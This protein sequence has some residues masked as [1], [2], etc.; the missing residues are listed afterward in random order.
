MLVL[1]H[2]AE[3][4]VWF[5]ALVLT[6]AL[7]LGLVQIYKVRG[8]EA[9]ERAWQ[10]QTARLDQAR[11]VLDSDL[12]ELVRTGESLAASLTDA[13]PAGRAAGHADSTVVD[14]ELLRSVAAHGA[15][16]GVYLMPGARYA[17]CYRPDASGAPQLVWDK[18]ERYLSP[19]EPGWL[20]PL[21]EGAGWRTFVDGHDGRWVAQYGVPFFLPD[22]EGVERAAGVVFVRLEYDELRQ[23]LRAIDLGDTGY[24]FLMTESGELI[25]HPLLHEGQVGVT[26]FDMATRLKDPLL[27]DAAERAILGDAPWIDRADPASGNMSRIFFRPLPSSRWTLVG[28][29]LHREVLGSDLTLRRESLHTGFASLLVVFCVI[30]LAASAT[31]RDRELQ[32]WAI[33]V[34]ASLV[35]IVAVVTLWRSA[36][37]SVEQSPTQVRVL[38]EGGLRTYLDRWQRAQPVRADGAP[39]VRV[40][41]PTGVYVQSLEFASAN[42]VRVTGLIW[43]RFAK[44]LPEELKKGF[45]LPEAVELEAEEVYRKPY[46]VAGVEEGEVVGTWF[47]AI[48]RQNF[49]FLRY[50]FDTKDV[51]V[52]LWPGAFE[53]GVV[54]VPDLN[55]YKL[56]NPTTFPGLDSD[57]VLA[58]W[59]PVASYFQYRRIAYTTDF[60]M[61]GYGGPDVPELYFTVDVRRNFV[62]SFVSDLIPLLVV[63]CLL[64][65]VQLTLTTENERLGATGFSFSAVLGA[66]LALVFVVVVA[67]IQLRTM[68]AGQPIVY[69]EWFYFAMYVL[70]VA[71]SLNGFVVA[72]PKPPRFVSY[73]DNLAPR[74]LFWP[75]LCGALFLVTLSY[76]YPG[77]DQRSRGE[78]SSHALFGAPLLLAQPDGAS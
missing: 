71:I 10:D 36:V 45:K 74:L 64:F 11:D 76:F 78:P 30:G 1:F 39:P 3:I 16:L 14:A 48:L 54:L 56:T 28:V 24:S 52:R 59:K 23:K 55:A 17:R 38:D 34:G 20:T 50:P 41:I 6:T 62:D 70:V 37:M 15:Q 68:L 58:G 22:A 60:G 53:R 2:R 75:A 12:G 51:W 61:A 32:L 18:S 4:R 49:Q 42:N 65:G 25:D 9:E 31:F 13:L 63:A 44:D 57:F 77:T 19:D 66:C 67:H 26:L 5:I 47:M 33:S 69:L 21:S 73:R 8:A 27:G 43:Q 72:L 46:S 7:L 35:L 40:T 29:S